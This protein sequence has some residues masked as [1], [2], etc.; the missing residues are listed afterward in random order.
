MA[1]ETFMH[2]HVLLLLVAVS[3]LAAQT[4]SRS[5]GHAAATITAADVMRRVH[6]IAD[7]SMMGRDTPSPGLEMTAQYVADEF[8]RF[9]LR[10]GGENG[11]YFQR[12]QISRS[13]LDPAASHVGFMLSGSHLHA[14]L[15]RDARYLYGGIPAREIGGP[16]TCSPASMI[17]NE[18]WART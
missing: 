17:P 2:R 12:Y 13:R 11:T 10:P 3:P 18:A 15:S 9:G 4:P 5:L 1:L 16:A 6:V 14:E 7:D 8:K